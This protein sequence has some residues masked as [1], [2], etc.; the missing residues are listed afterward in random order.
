MPPKK[1]VT[2]AAN[3]HKRVILFSALATVAFSASLYFLIPHEPVIE[4]KPINY[5]ISRIGTYDSHARSVMDQ[6]KNTKTKPAKLSP[7]LAAPYLIEAIVHKPTVFENLYRR[8]YQSLPAV[9]RTHCQPP[10]TK[11]IISSTRS[12]AAYCFGRL[13]PTNSWPDSLILPLVDALESDDN[14]VRIC[15]GIALVNYDRPIDFAVPRICQMIKTRSEKLNS[16]TVSILERS[17]PA[18]NSAI[19]YLKEYLESTNSHEWRI[20]CAHALWKLDKSQVA[21]SRQAALILSTNANPGTR[22]DSADL[23]WSIDKDPAVV[24]PIINRLLDEDDSTFDHRCMLTLKRIGPKAT[25]AAPS[26]AAWLSRN[27]AK[28]QRQAYLIKEAE[29]ILK[30]FPIGN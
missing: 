16:I 3:N 26:V 23:L 21:L 14:E 10:P 25:A 6:F 4:G 28:K 2:N 17:Q 22:I 12:E 30:A 27:R 7:N 24:V 11:Q 29:D 1:S 20:M 9:V 8:Y 5:W 15:S 18:A 13:H 19:P